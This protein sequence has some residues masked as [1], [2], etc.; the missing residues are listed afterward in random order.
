[1]LADAHG[2]VIHLGER[3]CSLQRRHQKVDR[4]GAVAAARHR[5]AGVD[6][7]ARPSRRPKA[8]GYTGAGT[9]EFIVDADRPPTSF[10][11]IEMNTRLQV[12]HPVT[13]LITGLDLVEQQLRVA[14]GEP[15]PLDQSD[16]CLDG[17]AI[18]ARVY[19]EDPARGFLPPAGTVLGL[20]EPSGAR[21]PRR[22]LARRRHRRRH[23][24]RP[25]AGQGHRLGARPRE[26]RPR[27]ARS[28][29]SG[30]PPS[31]G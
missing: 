8:V 24:L 31:S 20:V 2:N 23:R 22:Q 28:A 3:E 25:D 14:A 15:L 5:V 13:E 11:F 29:R 17:H 6:G 10:F 4:G 9:V 21:R 18:E 16:I 27:P 12:E 7:R 19:A 30:G 26:T 1:M